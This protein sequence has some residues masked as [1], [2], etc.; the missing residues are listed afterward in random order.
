MKADDWRLELSEDVGGMMVE[1]GAGRSRLNVSGIETELAVV[2]R[3]QVPPFCLPL[4]VRWRRRMTKEVDVIGLGRARRDGGD[5][6]AKAV[7]CQHR[8]G[9]RS[10]TAG[11]RH[12]DSEGAAL[13]AGHRGLNDRKRRPQIHKDFIFLHGRG[14]CSQQGVDNP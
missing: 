7:G 10:E 5:L 6:V 12:C 14:K 9:Q 11:V 8:G 4:G 2:G 13:N 1:R 3:E